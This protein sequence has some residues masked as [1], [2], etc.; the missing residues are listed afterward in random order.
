V[1]VF[2][3]EISD[4]H[5]RVTKLR[6]QP[7]AKT[8]EAWQQSVMIITDRC[9]ATQLFLPVRCDKWSP[10]KFEFHSDG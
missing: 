6:Q 3:D 7:A 10:K 5:Q 8:E 2:S 9:Q 1:L 4:C